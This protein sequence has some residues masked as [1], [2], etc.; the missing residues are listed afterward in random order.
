MSDV[1]RQTLRDLVAR[2]GP[3]LC[4]DARR[5]EGLLRD[6]CG[7]HRRE[8]NVLISALKQHV[9]LDLLAAQG[10]MPRGLL[11]ARLARRLEEQLAL[12]EEA[13]RWA[14]DSWALAL[15]VVTDAELQDRRRQTVKE[16]APPPAQT[17]GED[18]TEKT[19]GGS[20]TRAAP[21]AATQT[22]QP[23]GSRPAPQP[24]PPPAARQAGRRTTSPLPPS[25]PPLTPPTSPQR[26][27]A[28]RG[29][30]SNWVVRAGPRSS[31]SPT[32][33]AAQQ[34]AHT[35][36]PSPDPHARRRRGWS[37]RGCAVGCLLL[38]LLSLALFLGVPFVVS[39]LREEQQRRV[40]ETPPAMSP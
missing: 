10:A 36:A 16:A 31:A 27:R 14:V 13:A 34:P 4:S 22:R 29:P 37:L 9:P 17:T 1:P 2:H 21:P 19:S 15:G 11:L 18:E 23:H 5:C 38:A 26:Q 40:N 20:A 33:G 24:S 39:V 25:P 7:A 8:I 32:T 28:G 3:G 35:R 30:F 12:T 6:L